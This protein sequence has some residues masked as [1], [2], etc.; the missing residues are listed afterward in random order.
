[1]TRS[2]TGATA[3]VTGGSSG[4]G[5]AIAASLAR[6]GVRLALVGRDAGRLR[7]AAAS[8]PGDTPPFVLPADLENVDSITAVSLAIGDRWGVLDVLVHS[9]GAVAL[10]PVRSMPVAE[11]DRQY[12]VNLRAPF[13]LTQAL[14]PLLEASR[15]QIV[16]VNSSAGLD[17]RAGVSAYAASKHALKALA[18]SVRHEVHAAGVRVLSVY[19]GRTATPM[20]QAVRRMEGKAFLAESCLQPEDVA[21]TILAALTLPATAEVKDISMRPLRD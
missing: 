8:L 19:P 5:L 12:R 13:V 11:L 15:G 10:G 2:L 14:L 18:D 21:A 3:L 17:A 9:A 16:F 7:A 1:M 4:I 6:V 20:Q